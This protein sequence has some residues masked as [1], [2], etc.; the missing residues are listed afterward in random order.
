MTITSAAACTPNLELKTLVRMNVDDEAAV[1]AT[2]TFDAEPSVWTPDGSGATTIWKQRRETPLD[3]QWIGIDFGAPSATALVSPPLTAGTGEVTISFDHAYDFELTDGTLWDGGVVEVTTDGGETWVDIGAMASPAYTGV[4]TNESGNPLADRMAYSGQNADFPAKEHVT[5]PLG[6]SLRGK[7]FQ[8]R[9]LIGTDQSVGATG[10]Q[11]DDLQITGLTGK[12]FP[13]QTDDAGACNP[14]A[15]KDDGGCCQT[16]G[17]RTGNLI[18]GLLVLGAL[19]G[20]RR[21]RRG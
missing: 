9:F 15:A 13:S 1:S 6:S 17:G 20:R 19:L 4:I 16:G 10:W 5:I 8:V 14:D 18:A 12:P 3:G 7:T 11:L 21:R 2:D